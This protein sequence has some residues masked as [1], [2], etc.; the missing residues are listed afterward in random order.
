[1]AN[2]FI[3]DEEIVTRQDG[4]KR[5]LFCNFSCK[6]Q[7]TKAG[8]RYVPS[9]SEFTVVISENMANKLIDEGFRID[10]YLNRDEETEYKL[11]VKIRFDNFPPVVYKICDG[12]KLKLN[13]ETIKT[14]DR[15]KNS[16]IKLDMSVN[17]SKDGACYM[18]KGAFHI[19]AD[20]FDSIYGMDG[21][22]DAE[23]DDEFEE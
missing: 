14:L 8:K 1:M 6:E 12:H 20:E 4:T 7:V 15:D 16:V 18:N 17:L 2:I 23:E 21:F 13:A 9:C 3:R 11:K 5:L 10:T 22:E 19:D